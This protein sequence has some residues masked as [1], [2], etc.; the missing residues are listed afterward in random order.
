MTTPIVWTCDHCSQ[1][2]QTGWLTIDPTAPT[3]GHPMAW[4]VYCHDH[5]PPA[6]NG[7]YAIPLEQVPTTRR[8]AVLR[9]QLEGKR[10]FRSTIFPNPEEVVA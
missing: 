9:A 1:P 2:T 5:A 10:W 8:L 3:A 7:E 4:G 6:Y